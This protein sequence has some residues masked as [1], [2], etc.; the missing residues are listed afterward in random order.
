MQKEDKMDVKRTMPFIILHGFCLLVFFVGWSWFAFF[1][2]IAFDHFRM[3]AIYGVLPSLFSHR[4]YNIGVLASSSL[5]SFS[6]TTGPC[7]RGALW[8][9]STHRHHH[10][11][12]DDEHDIHSPRHKGFWWSHIGNT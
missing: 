9:A 10:K 2:A 4:A 8:W 1:A 5:R 6:Y 3:F 12:S 11:H 7:Q